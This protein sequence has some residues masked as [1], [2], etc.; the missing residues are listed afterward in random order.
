MKPKWPPTFGVEGKE[1][2]L[3]FW[4]RQTGN[5]YFQN[6]I[7]FTISVGHTVSFGLLWLKPAKSPVSWLWSDSGPMSDIVITMASPFPHICGN[8]DTVAIIMSDHWSTAYS[9]ITIGKCAQPI[10]DFLF[11][12]KIQENNPNWRRYLYHH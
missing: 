9:Q 3:G 8:G 10:G 1:C 12:S 4:I 5:K 6:Q 11:Y 7:T 2:R